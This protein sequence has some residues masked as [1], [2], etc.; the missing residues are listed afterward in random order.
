MSIARAEENAKGLRSLIGGFFYAEEVPYGLALVRI[1]MPWVIFVPMIPRWLQARELYSSDGA[2]TPLWFSYGYPGL[3]P[4]LSAPIIIAAFSV[5]LF[6]LL[7]LS[8]GWCSRTCA[9]VSFIIYTYINLADA[10]STITKYSV[11]VSHVLLLLSLAECGAVWSVDA[12]IRARRL[13]RQGLE[14]G[15][16]PRFAAWPRRLMQLF[17]GIVYFGAAITKMH[18]PAFFSGDQL[19]TWMITD[20]NFPYEIGEYLAV[21]PAVL[22]VFAYITIVWE[23]TFLFLAWRDWAR[24][25]M[26]SLGVLFHFMTTLTLGL[27]VF[28]MV[29]TTTYFC[30]FNEQDA[31][32]WAARLGRLRQRIPAP[33]WLTSIAAAVPRLRIPEAVKLPV[34]LLFAFAAISTAALGV[35][36]EHLIDPY[37]QRRAEGPYVL[38]QLD[39]ELVESTYLSPSQP[40][41]QADKVLAVDAGSILIGGILADPHDTFNV[42]DMM[43]V[44]CTLNP[45]HEDM[46]V[47][48]SLINASSRIIGRQPQMIPRESLRSNFVF[49]LADSI[50][51]GLYFLVLKVAGKEV[52]RKEITIQAPQGRAAAPVA[53]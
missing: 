14:P 27:Y 46:W 42:G 28:P 5:M 49:E 48:C 22:V 33:Q 13:R 53:N 26:L 51:S 38:E 12:W 41:R 47:E 45:P 52:L 10:V 35:E 6:C 17:V 9:F 3:L 36:I 11:I 23:V 43:T 39:S 21:Y 31:R 29:C 16:P 20:V 4:E 30:F 32:A 40:V 34:P 25:I 1:V 7:S 37:G 15:D 8:L 44:Q 24:V 19:Q 2:P 50:D 18:T